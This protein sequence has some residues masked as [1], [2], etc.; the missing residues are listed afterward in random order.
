MQMLTYCYLLHLST[1][2]IAR[3]GPGMAF[4]IAFGWKAEPL[5]VVLASPGEETQVALNWQGQRTC[6]L[7]KSPNKISGI[8]Y[9]DD[10]D[11]C[12]VKRM[13][14]EKILIKIIKGDMVI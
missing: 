7:D 3:G 9:D 8:I 5:K 11:Y 10:D 6:L 1:K 12:D 4:L 14:S 2:A 13:S